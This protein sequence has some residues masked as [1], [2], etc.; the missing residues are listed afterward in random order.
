[1]SLGMTAFTFFTHDTYA[2]ILERYEVPISY[3]HPPLT[4]LLTNPLEAL[5]FA[6]RL[7]RGPEALVLLGRVLWILTSLLSFAGVILYALRRPLSP[8]FLLVLG[9][10]AYFALTSSVIGLAI[11]GRFRIPVNPFIFIFAV[12]AIETMLQKRP[13]GDKA[14]TRTYLLPVGR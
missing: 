6:V 1:M 9:T 2:M 11:N 4:T 13:D 7:L 12:Y 3:A 10:V 14:V 8:A 5:R